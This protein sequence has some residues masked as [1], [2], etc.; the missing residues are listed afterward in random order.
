VIRDESVKSKIN[1]IATVLLMYLF[2]EALSLLCLFV[3]KPHNIRY[4]PIVSTLTARQKTDL[5]NFLTQVAN[6]TEEH[7]NLD[8]ATGWV[9][10]PPDANSAG[11]R[12]NR[13]YA[14]A[15]QPGT[16]RISA[17]GASITYADEVALEDAWT[18]RMT[19]LAPSVEVLNY[20]VKGYGLD[21]AYLRYLEE[22]LKYHPSAV[23]IG[24]SAEDLIRDVL[25]FWPFKEGANARAVAKPRFQMRNGQLTLLPNPLSSVAE[26]QNLLRNDAQVMQDLGQADYYY[27]NGY[28][29]GPLDFSPSVRLAKVFWSICAIRW[30]QPTFQRNGAYNV[31]SEAYQVT[32]GIFDAFYRKILENGALPVILVFPLPVDYDRSHQGKPRRY[33]ALL[34]QFRA[35]GYRFIDVQ[36]ALDAAGSGTRESQLYTKNGWHLSPLGNTL[37]AKYILS[38]LNAW[39]LLDASKLAQAAQAERKQLSPENH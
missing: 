9:T 26:Y 36:D 3:L 22:G 4:D 33:A 31:K 23:L 1:V 13:E 5:G 28:R 14:T 17:F 30:R 12:D 24:Y 6:G 37:V 27:Q 20:G 29:R 35:R 18:K 21:Q 10:A 16:V 11:M 39:D 19:A 38:Q 34:A 2:I 32:T 15:P 8:A 7:T 25:V